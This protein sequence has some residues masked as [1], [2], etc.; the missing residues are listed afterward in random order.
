MNL[1]FA[2]EMK[3]LRI[4]RREKQNG[5]ARLRS[6]WTSLIG[7]HEVYSRQ[8]KN[9]GEDREARTRGK[10]EPLFLSSEEPTVVHQQSPT[11]WSLYWSSRNHVSRELPGG[12][13]VR[14]PCFHCRGHRS[15]VGQLRSCMP[16]RMV[17]KK[18]KK[19]RNSVSRQTEPEPAP[20][21]ASKRF[22]PFL[23][24]SS[25]WPTRGGGPREV[26]WPN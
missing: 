25:K 26:L 19:K 20:L 7:N 17:K 6:W 22:L 21:R 13:V 12:P 1:L 23:E 8:T 16:C 11:T 2:E 14:A 10:V 18:K 9:N 15:L 4:G 5:K 3:I 24:K